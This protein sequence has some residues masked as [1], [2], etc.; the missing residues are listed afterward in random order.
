VLWLG[1]EACSRA[2]EHEFDVVE[3]QDVGL[4]EGRNEG[5]CKIE[6]I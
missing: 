5:R 6:F 4:W 2:G 1:T 3:C